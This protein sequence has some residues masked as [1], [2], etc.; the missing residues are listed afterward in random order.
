MIISNMKSPKIIEKI[1]NVQVKNHASHCGRKV[2]YKLNNVN[3]NSVL[4]R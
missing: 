4:S 3:I 2:T 1:N